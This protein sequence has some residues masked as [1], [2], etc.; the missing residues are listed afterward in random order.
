MIKTLPIFYFRPMIVSIDD[1]INVLNSLTTLLSKKF[2]ITTFLEPNEF[3]AFINK[4]CSPLTGLNLLRGC[5]ESEYNDLHNSLVEFKF[6]EIHNLFNQQDQLS[7]TVAVITLDYSMP[8]TD[9]VSLSK[10]LNDYTVKKILF[11]GSDNY[12]LG[13]QAR[14][15]ELIDRFVNKSVNPEH[16]LEII[17]EL[18]FKY[19]ETITNS[20]KQHIEAETPLPLSD[21]LFVNYCLKLFK[22]LKIK[23]YY[24]IDKDGALCM[25]SEDEQK[26]LLTIYTANSLDQVGRLIKDEPSLIDTY[27]LITQR[28]KIPLKHLSYEEFDLVS[29]SENLVEPELLLGK[30]VYYF[31]IRILD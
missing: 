9:G 26:Y 2:K 5:E 19:Y 25:I 17:E 6:S 20:L 31:N 13:H 23:G 15:D 29:L 30:E 4:H 1:D 21:K 16:L 11:T 7:S 27:T 3:L 12:E 14:D 24:L 18:T 8:T 28:K 22:K 10:Q